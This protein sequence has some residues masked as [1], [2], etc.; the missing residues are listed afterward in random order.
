MGDFG[1]GSAGKILNTIATLGGLFSGKIDKNV[2]KALDGMRLAMA[3]SFGV[4][5]AFMSETGA[6]QAK[7]VGILRRLWDSVILVA[8][9]KL[10]TWIKRAHK[11]LDKTLGPIL[12]TLLK[13]RKKL[14]DFYKHWFRPIFDTIDA[15]RHVLRVLSFLHIDI[16][17]KIDRRLGEFES[18]VTEKFGYVLGKINKLIAATELVIDEFGFYQRYTLVRS[19]VL[20]ERDYWKTLWISAHKRERENPKASPAAVKELTAAAAASELRAVA[21]DG[22]RSTNG[23]AAEESATLRIYVLG[24]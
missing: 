7:G 24:H 20:Y 11:W 16:A 1:T 15:V 8:L 2:K 19:M 10:D 4:V 17:G 14:L 23:R 22:D 13:Y 9:L 3:F 6:K 18:W 21:L 5:A 12:R